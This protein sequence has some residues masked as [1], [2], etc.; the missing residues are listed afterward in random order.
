MFEGKK[1]GF[2]LMRL[3]LTDANDKGSIDIEALKEMVDAFIEQGFTYF[4]TAWMY[5]AF[6][7]EDA[8]KEAL[9]DRYPRDRYTL[10][11]KLHASYLKK[12]EDRDRIFEEQR[13]KTGVEYFDYYLI[14]A[15][16]QELY[17]IYNEMDCFN[18]LIEKRK[19]GLVKHIGFSYHDSAEFL[20]QV[21]TEHPEMEFVQLQMN[22]LDW[23]SAEVQSRKCYEVA[24]KHGKPVIVMEP[25][26]GGTLADVPA[27]VR[28][29]FAA[30]HPDLS[31]PSW[32]IRFVASLDN[33]AMVLSGMSNMEQLMDNISYMK[34]F[35]PM[36]AEETE[37]VH[38]AAEMIK[39]SIAIP[40]TGCS[41]CTEGCPMQIAIPDLFRVYNKS[42]RGEISDVEADEEYRQL[43]ES[44]GKAREC[45]ACGQCQVACPQHLEIINYLKDVAKCMEKQD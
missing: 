4:D 12:K 41:Y 40:C 39:D 25:V 23:E 11:T 2:G 36:N 28:E 26:K 35:V 43:T 8:V 16:D 15:I 18:W 6:K 45:L 44:G 29:S 42:K 33:V 37:L 32:A 19:Q 10:T 22:Y 13:Q 1:L 14:H 30:Y 7:S 27:E 38:K 5:C 20:D 17:S 3:P 24:S 9:T 31:V 34:E 21:L